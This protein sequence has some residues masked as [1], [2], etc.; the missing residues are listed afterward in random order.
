MSDLTMKALDLLKADKPM[1]LE[2]LDSVEVRDNL[3]VLAAKDADLATT[4]LGSLAA[5]TAEAIG[6]EQD[7][8]KIKAYFDSASNTQRK[9]IASACDMS[10][11]LGYA[12]AEMY[13]LMACFGFSCRYSLPMSGIGDIVL[14]GIQIGLPPEIFHKFLESMPVQGEDSGIDWDS[15]EF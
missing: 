15:V 2:L 1:D 7:D 11:A 14:K 13:P 6:N 3:L 5:A 9:R 10:M 12:Y 4:L 8:D